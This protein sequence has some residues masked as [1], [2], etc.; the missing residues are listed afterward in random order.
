[1][2]IS[3]PTYLVDRS[4]PSFSFNPT[5][6]RTE[7]QRISIN[8]TL[9][10]VIA[11]NPPGCSYLEPHVDVEDLT[12][13]RRWRGHAC[14]AAQSRRTCPDLREKKRDGENHN[15][16]GPS[17]QPR[18]LVP[19]T[20]RP[21]KWLFDKFCKRSSQI[22]PRPSSRMA[23]MNIS[24][25]TYLVDRSCPSFSFNPTG[26]LVEIPNGESKD[27]DQCHITCDSTTTAKLFRLK[28]ISGCRGPN[29]SSWMARV[30]L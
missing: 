14:I 9:L 4:C 16:G 21:L 13:P 6:I 17:G 20:R 18:R 24:A 12:F 26:I 8:A 5:Y 29:V 19:P 1:M 11:A 28:A 3:A 7:S 15:S 30:R 27:L 22:T 23:Q 10:P 2:N 25:L